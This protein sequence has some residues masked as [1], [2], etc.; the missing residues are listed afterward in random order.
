MF[1]RLDQ[2]LADFFSFLDKKVGKGNYLVFL[3]ADHGAS[4]AA[5][6]LKAHQIPAGLVVIRNLM[7]GMN[8]TLTSVYCTKR[9]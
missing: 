5:N 4:H 6:F 9:H 3:T 7:K 2:D 1:L 8:D